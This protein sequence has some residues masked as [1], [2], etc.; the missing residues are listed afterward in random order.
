MCIRDRYNIY[1]YD[2]NTAVVTGVSGTNTSIYQTSNG[3]TTWTVANTH[4]GFGDDMFMTDASTAYFIGDPSGG[5]WDLLKS[6][7][8]GLNWAPW[9]TLATT[10]TSGTY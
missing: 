2:A 3:G 1:A 9:T 5:N 4:P 7:N 8:A 6:T 10:N